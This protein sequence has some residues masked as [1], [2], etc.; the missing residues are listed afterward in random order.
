MHCTLPQKITSPRIGLVFVAEFASHSV[1]RLAVVYDAGI[2][3]TVKGLSFTASFLYSS[4]AFPSPLVGIV[5]GSE[6]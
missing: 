2:D 6:V 3:C 5:C 1:S 4:Q